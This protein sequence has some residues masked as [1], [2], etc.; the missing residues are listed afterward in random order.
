MIYAADIGYSYF[1]GIGNGKRVFYPSVLGEI[2]TQLLGQDGYL[3]V[4][5]DDGAWFIGDGA[6][7]Q[8]LNL[9]RGGQ[10]KDWAKTPMYR[11]LL[12]AG[13]SEVV[14]PATHEVAIDLASGLP[15]ADFS[16]RD[17]VVGLLTGTH[18]VKRPGRRNLEITI[19]NALFVPQALA[20]FDGNL[21]NGQTLVVLDIGGRNIN[22]STFT[23][24]RAI[25]TQCGS[26]ESGMLNIVEQIARQI[27]TKTGRDLKTHQAIEAMKTHQVRA[28][29]RV[30]DV[31][32]IVTGELEMFVNSVHTLVSSRWGDTSAVDI[33]LIAGGGALMVGE[34]IARNYLQARIVDDPQWANVNGYL[35]YGRLKFGTQ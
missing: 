19:R 35:R 18:L 21:D 24:K 10:D 5:T 33:M 14:S 32:D 26:T 7:E 4:E 6:I 8:S 3:Q 11:A 17:E 28:Y 16:M 25:A 12:L 23:G 15:V 13:I 22:Y 2:R 9:I 29:G 27:K 34:Q 1:K 30:C 20:A 31:G